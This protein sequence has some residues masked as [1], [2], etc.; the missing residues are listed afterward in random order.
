MCNLP[1]FPARHDPRMPL[2]KGHECAI[3]RVS[4]LNRT[5]VCHKYTIHSLKMGIETTL[6]WNAT[7]HPVTSW[8]LSA[9]QA[10]L[11]IACFVDREIA[12]PSRGGPPYYRGG[13]GVG[14]R[15]QLESFFFNL[16]A[17]FNLWPAQKMQLRSCCPPKRG[18]KW[19]H[20][21][22][23]DSVV[24][25]LRHNSEKYIGNIATNQL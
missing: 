15:S 25:L 21:N 20:F 9:P 23:S 6:S 2:T 4:P 1:R 11:K 13:R 14:P 22:N 16:G 17:I 5:R 12:G 19:N 24:C 7:F 10:P 3:C 18:H 8:N